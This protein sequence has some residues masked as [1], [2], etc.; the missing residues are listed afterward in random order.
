MS[1]LVSKS[2]AELLQAFD[3]LLNLRKHDM[4]KGGERRNSGHVPA[5]EFHC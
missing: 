4:G 2:I 5:D 1:R 3:C